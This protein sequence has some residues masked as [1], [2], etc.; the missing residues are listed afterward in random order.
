MWGPVT[1]ATAHAL[2]SWRCALRGWQEGARGARLLPPS[3]VSGV[4]HS[5]S[6]DHTFLGR[7]AGLVARFLWAPGPRALGRLPNTTAPAIP[8]WRCALWRWQEVARGGE[9][10]PGASVR[11]VWRWTL[12]LPQLPSLGR[13]IGARCPLSFGA[14]GAGVGACHQPHS[15][16]SCELALRAV[17]AVGGGQGG[18]SFLRRRKFLSAEPVIL[19]YNARS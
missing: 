4:G 1:N 6:P 19:S 10:E 15:A 7:A 5:P 18:S 14:G 8:R 3:G 17:G 13:A 16:R 12:S 2:A 11:G 9:G